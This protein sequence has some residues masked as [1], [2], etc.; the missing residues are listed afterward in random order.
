MMLMLDADAAAAAGDDSEYSDDS[1]DDSE[2]EEEE[3]SEEEDKQKCQL[4]QKLDASTAKSLIE[5]VF[6]SFLDLEAVLNDPELLPLF[7][8]WPAS[9]VASLLNRDDLRVRSSLVLH[10]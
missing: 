4:R 6:R 1:D 7:K 9:V 10:L 5:H 2:E 3:E 8:S